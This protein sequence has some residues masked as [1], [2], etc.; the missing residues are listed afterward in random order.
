MKALVRYSHYPKKIKIKNI[1]FPKIGKSKKH[2]IIKVEYAGICGRDIEHYNSKL[3]KK[4]IPFV[5]GHE[6]AGSIYKLPNNL[7]KNFKIGDRVAC[8]T[9]D[10]VCEK[11]F[12]CKTSLYNLCNKRKNIGGTMNGAFASHIKVPIKYMHKISKRIS[13][14]EAALIEPMCVCYNALI[15]NSDIKKNDL[16]TIIGAGTM[17]LISLKFALYKKA[18]VI[19]IGGSKDVLQL[20]IAKKNGA[21]KIF[22]SSQNYVN[23]ISKFSKGKGSVLVVDT[24]GGSDETI[25]NA[26][27]IVSPNGQITKIGWFM[28]KPN[29]NFD[30]I[31]RKNIRLQGTFSHNYNIWEKCINLLKTKKIELQDLISAK[32]NIS[33]WKKSFDL[34]Q[35]R[36]AIKILMFSNE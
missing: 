25:K 1:K 7:K 4:K 28:K 30:K 3:N 18:R 10:K 13:Y 34:L 6:F 20:K 27:D 15:N 22:K 17:G 11:C 16:V 5:L 2:A 36:K 29:V 14:A 35:K 23:L 21:I 26:M 9:V 33:N 31:I 8:E 24:V 19:M 32:T 12:F